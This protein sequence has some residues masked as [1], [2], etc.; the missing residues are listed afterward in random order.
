MSEDVSHNNPIY[1]FMMNKLQRVLIN[2]LTRSIF[3]H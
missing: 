1:K 3:E 2:V